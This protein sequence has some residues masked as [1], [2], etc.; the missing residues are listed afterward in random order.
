MNSNIKEIEKYEKECKRRLK[1]TGVVW[2]LWLAAGCFGAH[3][4]YLNRKITGTIQL[5]TLGGFGL[6][7][8]SDAFFIN[9]MTKSENEKIKKQ[10]LSEIIQK[11][12]Y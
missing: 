9:R 7:A 12:K 10:I 3:R 4:F 1:E 6:W 8:I 11:R 2:A 5:F